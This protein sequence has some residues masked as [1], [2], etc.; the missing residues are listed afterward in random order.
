MPHHGF[1]LEASRRLHASP[2]SRH[3][4]FVGGRVNFLFARP[5]DEIDTTVEL[6]GRVSWEIFNKAHTLRDSRSKCGWQVTVT[7][8][9]TAIGLFAETG[10]R[11][12]S[13]GEGAWVATAGITARLPVV[14]TIGYHSS[15]CSGDSDD[16][17]SDSGSSSSSGGGGSRGSNPAPSGP[18][19]T[20]GK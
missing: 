16:G 7:H 9:V 15:S 14:A 1:Y 3:R 20:R 13:D 5:G 12:L 18:S 4:S 11:H 10:Y 8:G 2:R 6:A 19:S 17:G